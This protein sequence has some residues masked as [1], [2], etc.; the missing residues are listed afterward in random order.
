[1]IIVPLIHA[2]GKAC[3]QTAQHSSG[4][5]ALMRHDSDDAAD[6]ALEASLL[7]TL[8][9][10]A[11]MCLHSARMP[12]ESHGSPRLTRAFAA[13]LCLT[14]ATILPC[15]SLAALAPG[16]PL[17]FLHLQLTDIHAINGA[18]NCQAPALCLILHAVSDHSWELSV[19]LMADL[20]AS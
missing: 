20:L 1:M 16:T 19:R 9:F 13:L 4:G 2:G 14:L 5:L 3:M 11:G 15:G 17:H 8:R 6:G 18:A 7:T 10:L 12:V